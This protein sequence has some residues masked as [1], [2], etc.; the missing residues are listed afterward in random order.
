MKTLINPLLIAIALMMATAYTTFA[1]APASAQP[2][3]AF[4]SGIYTNKAGKLQIALDKQTGHSLQIRLADGSGQMV[5]VKRVGKQETTVRMQLDMSDLPD[6][7]YQLSITDGK[8]IT[9]HTV[10]L[11]TQ[12]PQDMSRLVAI[13]E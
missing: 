13:N 6:G 1:Q 2:S 7:A 5:F 10:T 11:G 12:K 4:Q 9:Q 8:N 3:P